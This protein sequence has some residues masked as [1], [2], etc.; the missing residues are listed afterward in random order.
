MDIKSAVEFLITVL[1]AVPL[2]VAA[3]M[4][5]TDFI[6]RNI[7]KAKSWG[8][9][10]PTEADWNELHAVIDPLREKLHSDDI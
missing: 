6:Q 5:V 8:D 1:Q 2:I 10:G 9:A 7:D 3:G 4:D